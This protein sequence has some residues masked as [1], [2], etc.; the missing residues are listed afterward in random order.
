[1]GPLLAYCDESARQEAEAST[2]RWRRG[3][4]LSSFDGVP[5]V[6]KEEIAV[7]G[8]STGGGTDLGDT[9]PAAQ[10]ATCVA[11]LRAAGAIVIGQAPM[12]EYGMTPLGFNPK[13]VMPRNPH[14]TDRIAG[15]SSTGSAVAVATGVVPFALGA[16][17]G[18]SIR[19]P[20][21]LCG[22]FGL[23]ATWGRVSR[24]GGLFGG[25]V[26]HL[27]PLASSTVDIARFLDAA[28]GPDPNDAQTELAPVMAPGSFARAL[29]RGV[30]GLRI[31]VDRAEWSDAA[32]EVARAGQDALRALEA[33]GAT[34]VDVH[35][36]L[37]RW[38]PAIGYLTIGLESVA[39]NWK[40]L[41]RRAAFSADLA[42][43]YASLSQASAVE[44]VQAQR[45]RA[46]LRVEVARTLRQVD[47]LALP[48]TRA[49]AVRVTDREFEGGFIDA[50][51]LD[52][53]CRF[54]FLGNLTGLPAIT[55]PVGLDEARLPIGLQ[56][57]GDA[58]DEATVL[59]AAAH[60]ERVGAARVERPTVSVDVLSQP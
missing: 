40:L 60:L 22:I 26:T 39:S 51:A 42:I 8:L 21:S 6:V 47:L 34:L 28:C 52:S 1:M 29:T 59:A 12:T 15:G 5:I 27:G 57:V 23:K 44:Y 54:N 17:G 24:Q 50:R 48:T 36:D 38:A 32:P 19:I 55:A 9:S 20:A 4:P 16:D 35:L 56:I 58:W 13:R 43:S 10:D 49:T 7:R 31:G 37:A 14:R 25:S 3:A 33:D 41:R 46:G 11:R 53:L 45:L 18:G 30:R 2:E